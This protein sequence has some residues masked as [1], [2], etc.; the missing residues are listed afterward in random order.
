[1]ALEVLKGSIG[2]QWNSFVKWMLYSRE[3]SE[4]VRSFFHWKND[5]LAITCTWYTF[6]Y[7]FE[8][9]SENLIITFVPWMLLSQ[10]KA[11]LRKRP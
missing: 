6:S 8:T 9:F 3:L 11:V 10:V 2:I 1:M 4:V 7:P 5:V